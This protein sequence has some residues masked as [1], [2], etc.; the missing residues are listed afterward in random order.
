MDSRYFDYDNNPA[1]T[2]QYLFKSS[3]QLTTLKKALHISKPNSFSKL[4]STVATKI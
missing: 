2:F 4:N 3:K 1:D